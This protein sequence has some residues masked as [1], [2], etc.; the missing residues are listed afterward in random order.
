MATYIPQQPSKRL[1]LIGL[2][3]SPYSLK[4]R[5]YLRYK[6]IPF[7][8][9]DRNR[10][11]EALFQK[12]A[13]VQ[14]IPLV[15][16]SEDDAMQDSTPI[17][18]RLE[19][20]V[21]EPSI[22]P[23]EPAARFISELLEEFGD[24]W[25]NKLMFQYRWGPKEDARSAAKRIT[26]LMMPEF[27]LKVLRPLLVP[28]MIRRMVPRMAF[29]GANGT[30]APHLERSWFRTVEI[31]NEHLEHR[32]YLFG[33]RPAFA[34]FGIW[35]NLNQAYSDPTCGRHLSQNAPALV[36]WIE[37]MDSPEA[38]GDFESLSSLLP[39]LAPLLEE[40]IAGRFL[41]WAVANAR[42]LE[43]DEKETSLEFDGTPYIQKTFKYH[44]WSFAQLKEK[45][46]R[47]S[48]DPFLRN[49]LAETGCAPFLS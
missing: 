25:C 12:H 37:R 46:S 9:V 31:L 48:Q 33:E 42:A 14:L 13:R 32:S 40:Q 47:A 23:V 27:P 16:F 17:I 1:R 19:S 11:N 49:I 30:N 10:K 22:H 36:H 18:E 28:F 34:D 15:L 44:A 8:W 6:K 21:P 35:G 5:S 26:A 41:P 39:S 20:E 4:V 24:E 3:M 2:T 7:E 45:F 43:L 38:K 29:A